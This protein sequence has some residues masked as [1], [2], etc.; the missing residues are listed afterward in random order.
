M[1]SDPRFLPPTPFTRLVRLQAASVIGDGALAGSLVGSLFFSGTTSGARDKVLLAL[2]LTLLPFAVVTPLLGPALDRVQ[3]GRR[4]ITVL[5]C[6]GRCVLCLVMSRYVTKPSPEGL[7]IYPLAFGAL[8][9][10]KGYAISRSALVP[11]VV[12]DAN[13]L[14]RANSRIALISN[15]FTPVGLLPALAM[16]KIFD[17]D[18][19]L[20]FAALV[21]AVATGLAWKLPRTEIKTD[22]QSQRLERAELHQ[23]S[24]LLA[25]SAMGVLRGTVGF[26]SFFAAFAFRDDKFVLGLVA[27]F[28]VAGAFIGNLSAPAIRSFAREEV[29]LSGALLGAAIVTVFGALLGG[30]FGFGVAALAIAIGSATGKLGFDSLLQRDGPDAVRGRAFAMFEARF[31]IIWVIGGMLGLIPVSKGVGLVCLALVLLFAG[32]SYAAGLRAA[33]G[34][35]SRS[36]LRPDAVDRAFDR[37]KAGVRERLR[38][39]SAARKASGRASSRGRRRPSPPRRPPL[40][41]RRELPDGGPRPEPPD[42]FP[43]GS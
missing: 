22:R 36:K 34:R 10:G 20:V 21:F 39:R 38:D 17:A 12:D 32:I 8:V 9:F 31:Q 35:V 33:R 23:P 24:V 19:S 37:A 27:T 11:T 40:P 15:V 26:T 5:C 4:L 25:G 41:P 16:E 7:L 29:M 18:V 3:G 28:A 43:G 6:L 30:S 2:V 13:E 42:V 1:S 14:V